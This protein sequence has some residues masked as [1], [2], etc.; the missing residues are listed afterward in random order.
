MS[1]RPFAAIEAG[2]TKC[3]LAIGH[4][5]DQ[6]LEHHRLPTGNGEVTVARLRDLLDAA[7][8]DAIGPLLVFLDLL[9]GQA[10]RRSELLLAHPEKGAALPHARPDVNVNR[11]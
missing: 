5:L 1:S 4:H 3:L 8:P 10:Y 9:E 6:W 2:G 7:R 11:M